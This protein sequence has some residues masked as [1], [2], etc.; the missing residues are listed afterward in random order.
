LTEIPESLTF[1]L[2]MNPMA[3]LKKYLFVLLAVLALI[4]C[5][6]KKPSLSGED[7]VAVDDFIGFFQPV[8]LAYQFSDSVFLKK[9]RDSLLI[10]WK[11][12]TQFIPDSVLHKA[13]A[14]GTKPKIYP[15]GK[16]EIPKAETYLFVKAVAGETKTVF[17]LSFDKDQQFIAGMPVL[18]RVPAS[19]IM[20][21]V[22]MD[23]KYSIIRTVQRKNSDGSISEGKDVYV[24]NEGA[25]NYMLIMTDPLDDK[26]TELIN[27]ID[28]L[29]RRNKLS[30]DYATGRMNIVSIRD[31]RKADRV[32]FFIHFEKNNGDCSGELKGEA[33]LR[34]PNL[35]EYR[36]SGDPCVLQFS[37][38][39]SSVALKEQD[40]CG[41]HRGVRC[42]FDGAYP[43]K[44]YVKP[45]TAAKPPVKK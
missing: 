42:L 29:S 44:R 16:V 31:G 34:S 41:S 40:G 6:H 26:V 3:V 39:S 5:K 37:F 24:L 27:P 11:V 38:T 17:I 28:T 19:S 9:E 20:Q 30:A 21:S 15:M 1:G 7:P 45:V 35:A 13:F 4:G 18:R 36:E 14:K 33:K 22:V 43:R 8:K 2:Q 23:K 12:F 10:S 32:T 25:R